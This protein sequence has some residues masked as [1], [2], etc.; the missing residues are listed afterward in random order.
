[1]FDVAGLSLF[2]NKSDDYLVLLGALN[3]VC[4][5]RMLQILS[6]TLNCETGHVSALPVP[7]ISHPDEINKIVLLCI[8]QSRS[9]WDS[10]ETSW[11]FKRHPLLRGLGS[12]QASFEAWE[13][14]ANERF[15][16]LKANEEELNR[17]F[18]DIYGLQDEL[19]PE[20]EEKDVTVRKA[21][22]GRDIRSLISYAVGCMFGRYSLDV[23]GLAYTGG[24]WDA[25]KYSSFPADKD[26][27]IPICDDEYFEDDIVGRFVE[28]IRVAYG[29][30]TLEENL[31]FIADALGGK[32][33]AR[34]VI[35]KYFRDD[36][37][38]D[39]LK[40][41][42]KRPIYWQFD[43]GK[44]G[45]FRALVYMHRYAPDTIARIRTDYVHQQQDRYRTALEGIEQRM[46]NVGT[47][48]RVKLSKVQK[49][50][51][52]QDKELHEYEEKIHHLADRFISIDLDDGVKKNYALFA[53]V[54]TKIK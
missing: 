41:Y 51:Q 3:S 42:Q 10:Y 39:H 36:F 28:F 54:L 27:I 31:R 12:V 15:Y 46:A 2:A 1:M 7:Q 43:S 52:E 22:L 8:N 49:K 4:V 40:I 16:Q 35:R 34:E 19:T 13:R 21:D 45:G 20:V 48:E 47:G 32:G 9:D 44:K 24:E 5:C 26:N 23:E 50:L 53:D 6:P 11:D 29:E 17:I 37:Y 18:I 14:E 33:S 30:D 38:A 25:S